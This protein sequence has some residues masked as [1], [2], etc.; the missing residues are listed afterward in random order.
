MS[1][2]MKLVKKIL[3]LFL[4]L[5]VMTQTC[6]ANGRERRAELIKI[7][8]EE[9]NEVVRLN[10]QI[11]AKNPKLLLRMAELY[12]EK[13]RIINEEENYR[14]ITLSPE[15]SKNINQEDFYKVSR[16]YFN[17]AQKTC[18]YILK[19]FKRFNGR[20]DV[21]YILAYNAKE[22]QQDDKAMAFFKKAL[23]YSKKNSYTQRKSKVALA[24]LYYN[25]KKYS[26]AIPLYAGA[27]KHK[28]DKWWTKDAFNLAWCYFRVG[29]TSKAINVMESVHRLS[30]SDKYVNIS[31]QVER[32]LA[33]FYSEAGQTNK[34]V[35]F[36]N[37]IGKDIGQNLL[38]VGI[39]LK[40][41][42]KY[43]SAESTLAKAATHAKSDETKNQIYIELLSLY[44][45][46]GKLAK[47]LDTSKNLF[48]SHKAGQ[49]TSQQ[50][51]DLKYHVANLSSRLQKQVVSKAYRR[52]KS[53]QN[54]KAE[55]ATEYFKMRAILEGSGE[56]KSIFHAAETQ[57]AIKNYDKAAALYDNA[58]DGAIA[59]RDKKIA[60]LSL[61]GLMASLG[62]KGVSKKTTDLYL[63]KAYT[64][65]L[66]GNPRTKKSYKI[67]QR[68]FSQKYEQGDIKGAEETLLQFKNF[69]P[70]AIDKQEAMLARVID[71]YKD[72]KDRP[73]ISIWVGKI[74]NGE[75]KVTKK[76]AKKL[77]LILLSMQFDKV[78]K[79]NTKG[80]KV[81][82]LRGYLEIY[83]EPTSSAEAKKNAAYNIAI[84]FH[85][86]GNVNET[87]GWAKRSLEL[88]TNADAYKF[89]DSYM[90]IASGLFNRRQFRRSAEINEMTLEKVCKKKSKIKNILFQNANVIYLAEDNAEKSYEVISFAKN[91]YIKSNIYLEAQLDL[92]KLLA[93]Q[94]R[95][96]SFD[97]LLTQLKR[98]RNAWGDIVYPL[99]QLRDA[100]FERGLRKEA[101]SANAEMISYF[102][103]AKASRQSI[104]LEGLDV[105]A[106][107]YIE[108]VKRSAEELSSMKLTFPE[109]KYNQLL[110]K[111]FAMIDD[112]TSKTLDLFK[113]GSGV[114][115][116]E[117]YKV[118]VES[119]Q[120][121]GE[122]I[123]SFTPPG[124]GAEYVTSFKSSMAQI[125]QTLI[126]KANDF[127][128]EAQGQIKKSQIL[129]KNNYFFMTNNKLPIV[130]QFFPSKSGVLMD[131]G[132]KR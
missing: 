2:N 9:L 104:P 82:A 126:N 97:N 51:E 12:L 32:D 117:G 93:E 79:F 27:L 84:L 90:A 24:E 81:A 107:N 31:D 42:G 88:M 102:K 20:A 109:N 96:E 129:A 78:E 33:Y 7:I 131:R 47:H 66:K 19:R 64:A 5:F 3:I 6:F 61:D 16:K 28:E 114:G 94:G 53:A 49:L 120:K 85:E 83:K 69:F 38:K 111:K 37:K 92:L 118:L 25:K 122:E 76:F 91:C 112:L 86:L 128:M 23:Q 110:K 50:S 18:Y 108:N 29:Q 63:T 71:H 13:A 119:Y 75:F 30:G 87:Y 77:R 36:Y 95:W 103:K 106:L 99:S 39:Y 124:K 70:A 56:Y 116:V 127:R 14:W 21:Y 89:E 60:R 59:A 62:G 52:N 48:A 130:P 8:D 46:H 132:G 15:E 41:Q 101:I 34:A 98:N 105:V 10:R 43:A 58:Y 17:M 65:Y 80:D 26:Q 73:N 40:G 125:A 57:Y 68:L 74:N 115:M 22:F 72:K 11:G 1:K 113:I 123:S 54:Q 100:Y 45:R 35:A 55:Y 4:S 44:E 121:M 67:Y